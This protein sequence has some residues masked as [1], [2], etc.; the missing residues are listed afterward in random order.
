MIQCKK[1]GKE[2]ELSKENFYTRPKSKTG[3]YSVCK[4]CQR[5][6][7][8]DTYSKYKEK[9]AQRGKIYRAKPHIRLKVK[10]KSKFSQKRFK[11]SCLYQTNSLSL[12]SN[13][14]TK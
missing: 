13:T 7:N 4:E 9:A 6:I 1:C 2:K 10:E 8:K 11:N 5:Q 14:K 3:F 12:Q